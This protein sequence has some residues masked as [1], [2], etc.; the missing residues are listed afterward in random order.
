MQMKLIMPV[1]AWVVAIVLLLGASRELRHQREFDEITRLSAD[2]LKTE[3]RRQALTQPDYL[4]IEKKIPLSGSLS[5]VAAGDGL[6]IKAA[7]LSD[8]AAWRLT[9]DQVL[10]ENTSV[11][12]KI[13]YLCSGKCPSGE[14]HK[15]VLTGSRIISR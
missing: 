11:I 1:I 6:T 3:T 4:A 12:W 8:Y 9:I 2:L 5:I 10:L 15:A 14:A 13:D 7:A